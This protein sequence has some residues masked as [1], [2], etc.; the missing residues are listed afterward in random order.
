MV[1]SVHK[2]PK[3]TKV[4]GDHKGPKGSKAQKVLKVHKEI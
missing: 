1:I 4:L 2:E 3:E